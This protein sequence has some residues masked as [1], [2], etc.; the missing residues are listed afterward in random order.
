MNN[1]DSRSAQAPAT[2]LA[3][4]PTEVMSH[5]LDPAK[6]ILVKIHGRNRA[7]MLVLAQA[8]GEMEWR[9]KSLDD[10]KAKAKHDRAVGRNNGL[11]VIERKRG[12]DD[13]GGIKVDHGHDLRKNNPIKAQNVSAPELLE[14]LQANGYA[15]LEVFFQSEGEHDDT[16]YVLQLTFRHGSAPAT[17]PSVHFGKVLRSAT[18]D[19]TV[20]TM[21]P[22]FIAAMKELTASTVDVWD[23]P[24]K[25]APAT[26]GSTDLVMQP[27]TLTINFSGPVKQPAKN[28]LGFENGKLV[29]TAVP[30]APKAPAAAP[31][32]AQ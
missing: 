16:K 9:E 10:Q 14:S 1:S 4:V 5:A 25:P 28:V 24:E 22:R 19:E 15:P 13:P 32:A 8:V 11:G 26:E 6:V 20:A 18:K 2:T 30:K 7:T 21:F 17:K 29:L 23:N 31:T 27:G 12:E 3:T